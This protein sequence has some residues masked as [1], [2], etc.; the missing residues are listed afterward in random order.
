MEERADIIVCNPSAQDIEDEKFDLDFSLIVV[1]DTSLD[2]ILHA[3]RNV[4][5]I[6]KVVGSELEL[7]DDE[8]SGEETA[9]STE[10][11]AERKPAQK[12]ASAVPA[13]NDKKPAGKPV[14]NRTVRVDIENWMF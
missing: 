10:T 3:A 8:A 2:E 1:T 11:A 9:V 4:S 13:K 14:V 12:T 5:E 6:D 7:K